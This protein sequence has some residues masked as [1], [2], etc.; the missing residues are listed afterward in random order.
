MQNLTRRRFF[1]DSVMAAATAALPAP[2]FAAEKVSTSPNEKLRAAVI[3]CG[4][5][6]KVHAGEVARMPD[7]ELAYLCDPD[8]DR[9]DEVGE[10]VVKAK[11]PM[12][13]KV[14]DLR[15]IMDDKSVDV[16]FIAAPNHWHSL[17]AIWAMQAGRTC[18][19]RSRSAT[20]SSKAPAWCRPR[21]S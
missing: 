12:P 2:L 4:I 20:M 14:Q 19:W 6:G 21:G 10:L 11:R 16:V 18:M 3:G 17:A 15:V 5:R 13:K 9:A 8:L 1:E 7:V